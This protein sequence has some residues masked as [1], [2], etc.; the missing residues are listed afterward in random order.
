MTK[1]DSSFD[2]ADQLEPKCVAALEGLTIVAIAAG[3]DHS[4]AVTMSGEAYTWGSGWNGQLGH[5]DDEGQSVPRRV[6]SFSSNPPPYTKPFSLP[7][8]KVNNP[9]VFS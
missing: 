3:R 6:D 5:G 1:L 8:C 4:A 2:Q 7:Y 9:L